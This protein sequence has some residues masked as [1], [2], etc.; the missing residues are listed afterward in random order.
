MAA[1]GVLLEVGRWEAQRSVPRRVGQRQ[2]A[3]GQQRREG[4]CRQGPNV[5]RRVVSGKL[6]GWGS[7]P[8]PV[9]HQSVRPSEGGE[10]ILLPGKQQ[11]WLLGRPGVA[12][13][14]PG[15]RGMGPGA[16][17]G[18]LGRPAGRWRALAR[19]VLF[20]NG[21][22]RVRRAARETARCV[23][24]AANSATCSPVESGGSL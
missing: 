1:K 24:Y 15:Q 8:V 22:T 20:A 13:E 7:G 6:A 4:N 16:G 17:G 12:G 10:G 9:Q 18:G 23:M 3:W 2:W 19:S 14:P 21:T 5:R 11:G